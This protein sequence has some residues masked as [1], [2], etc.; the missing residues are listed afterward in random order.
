M[1]PP[2]SRRSCNERA[3]SMALRKAEMVK[4]ETVVRLGSGMPAPSGQVPFAWAWWENE[5][6]TTRAAGSSS[7]ATTA[8]G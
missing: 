6:P 4:R 8:T 3:L 7:Q 5:A 2:R 1:T